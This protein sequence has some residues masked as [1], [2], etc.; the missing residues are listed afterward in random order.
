M[1][2]N[3]FTPYSTIQA[4]ENEELVPWFQPIVCAHTGHLSG[5]EILIRRKD[6]QSVEGIP[7]T[8]I[9]QIEDSGR[10]VPVT[11][12]IMEKTTEILLSVKE[13]LPFNFYVTFN[14]TA[15]CL[16]STEFEKACIQFIQ[17]P[18][19]RNVKLVLELTER[20]PVPVTTDICQ[21]L[22]RLRQHGISIALDDF[23]TGYNGY[24]YLQKF[25]VNLIKLDKT[26]VQASVT[27][28]IAG[29][30]IDSIIT[31]SHKPG[32]KVVAEGTE[33][34][35]QVC[36]A[37]NRDADYLQGYFFSPPVNGKQFITEWL[38]RD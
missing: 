16:L 9:S 26:F 18:E 17:H 2:T 31:L 15:E 19:N 27:D 33:T 20:S 25:P 30:I 1:T 6:Q 3:T 34:L 21:A 28:E 32:C 29:N 35:V 24:R 7:K 36:S 4:L 13:D 22:Y 14:V 10:I 38:K 11:C 23:G 8:F 5:C 37:L 12:S